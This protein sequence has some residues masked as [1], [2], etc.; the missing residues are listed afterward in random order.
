MKKIIVFI[1]L[2]LIIPIVSNL[3]PTFLNP[4]KKLHQGKWPSTAV[5]IWTA[6]SGMTSALAHLF[7]QEM[8]HSFR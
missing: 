8:K 3:F 4:L 6:L 7:F 1:L 5:V 2:S